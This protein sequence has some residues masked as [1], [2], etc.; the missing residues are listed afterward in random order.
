[1]LFCVGRDATVL[2]ASVVYNAVNPPYEKWATDWPPIA[3]S[4]LRYAE[5]TGALLVTCSNLYGYG[6]GNEVMT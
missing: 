5:A 3:N 4:L 6:K 1:M 2:H